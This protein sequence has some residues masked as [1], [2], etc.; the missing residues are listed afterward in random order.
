MPAKATPK[1]KSEKKP[2]KK[3]KEIAAPKASALKSIPFWIGFDLG[4]TK[5]LA[6]VL[7]KDYHVLG[8][9]RKSTNGSDGQIKGRKKI[10]T[11]IQEAIATSGVDPKGL[12]GIGI[13]C[14]GLVNPEKGILINAPNLGWKNMGLTGILKTAFK[15]PVS[16]LNDVDAGTFGEYK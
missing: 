9:A 7:D 11:A 6:C 16:V 13:G 3:I 2:G 1:K 5:M 10:I 15:K 14:P 4:G 8:T 12:Q